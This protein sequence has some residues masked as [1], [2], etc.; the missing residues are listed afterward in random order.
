MSLQILAVAFPAGFVGLPVGNYS[1]II[2]TTVI[3]PSLLIKE[4]Y[5]AFENR[6]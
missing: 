2:D 1:S 6:Q 4:T 5:G 3:E